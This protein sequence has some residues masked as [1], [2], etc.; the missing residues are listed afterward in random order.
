MFNDKICVSKPD[1]LGDPLEREITASSKI[2]QCGVEIT[3]LTKTVSE[4]NGGEK[5]ATKVNGKIK[6]KTEHWSEKN[7]RHKK[8]KGQV[9]LI[10]GPLRSLIKLPCVIT[11]TRHAPRRLGKFDNLPMAF[12]WILD[13]VCE[14][15]TGEYRPG[16][17]DDDIEDE[18]DVVYRQVISKKYAVIIQ[19]QN[20]NAPLSGENLPFPD[21]MAKEP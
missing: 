13:A 7:Y 9:H 14:V 6:Y 15:I 4:S 21:P 19:I 11:M 16:K 3:I 12:K 5:K 17:A 8:Q 20:L 1:E 10:L 2:T 18:I